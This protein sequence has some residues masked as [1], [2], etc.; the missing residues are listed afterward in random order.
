MT[1]GLEEPWPSASL[2]NGIAAAGAMLSQMGGLYEHGYEPIRNLLLEGRDAGEF[3]FDDV[4]LALTALFGATVTYAMLAAQR[5][6]EVPADGVAAIT[7]LVLNGLRTEA[8]IT[9]S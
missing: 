3:R 9:C 8:T 7:A 1:L 4:D 6:G 2:V 5:I